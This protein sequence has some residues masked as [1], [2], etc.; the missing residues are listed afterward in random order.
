MD[1]VAVGLEYVPEKEPPD[2]CASKWWDACAMCWWGPLV[3]V[4]LLV[5][6]VMM[7]LCALGVGRAC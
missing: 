3:G 2:C 5:W 7:T 4:V 1:V 6:L